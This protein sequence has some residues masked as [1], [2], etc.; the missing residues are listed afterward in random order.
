MCD[1][2]IS[3][4]E[5]LGATV[6]A[7]LEFCYCSKWMLLPARIFWLTNGCCWDLKKEIDDC[8]VSY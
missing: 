5:E 4:G 1:R 7:L 3:I 6:A 2:V 8:L